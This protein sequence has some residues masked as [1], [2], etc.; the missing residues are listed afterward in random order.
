MNCLTCDRM[1]LKAFP[2][3]AAQG[4]GHCPLSPVGSFQVL[5]RERQ[6]DKFKPADPAV[7]AARIEWDKKR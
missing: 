3:H 7:A 5:R 4:V 6:C 2:Q 1:N